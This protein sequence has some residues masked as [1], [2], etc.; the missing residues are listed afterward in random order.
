MIGGDLARIMAAGTVAVASLVVGNAHAE[1]A[2]ARLAV[3]DGL[4]PEWAPALQLLSTELAALR[5]SDC[6]PMEISIERTDRAVLVIATTSD[7]RRAQR[8]VRDPEALAAT[9]IGLLTTIPAEPAPPSAAPTSVPV[10]S[11]APTVVQRPGLWVGF[12]AGVRL[13][14]PTDLTVLDVELRTDLMLGRWSLLATIRSAVVS[15][16]GQQGVDCDV[17]NDVSLGLGVGRRIV[18]GSPVVDVAVEPSL[19]VMHMEL[20]AP[21]GNEAQSVDGTLVTLRIDASVRLAVPLGD[22][23][24]ITLTLDA[25]LAPSLLAS[26]TRLELPAVFGSELA[27]PFPAWTGGVRVGASGAVL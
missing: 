4:P 17:Y 5:R 18:A 26:P 22:S 8:V 15:C 6:E 23:W 16:L 19:T 7:G 12:G 20:D 14:A 21:D 25:G 1:E 10:R 3:G 2:C 24:H 27:P 11:A 13:T 9:V